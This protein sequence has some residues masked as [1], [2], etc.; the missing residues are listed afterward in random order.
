M[1]LLRFSW[2][3]QEALWEMVETEALRL[4]P[5]DEADLPRIRERMRKYR[6]LP[7]DLADA[8][9]VRI[10][11]RETLRRVFTLDRRN[12]AV[13]RPA[14]WDGFPCYPYPDFCPNTGGTVVL[15]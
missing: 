2:Q 10:A 4:L 5:L 8:A 13:Y 12:F 3:A 7:M 9:L 15:R 14:W 1:H 6:D 11:E